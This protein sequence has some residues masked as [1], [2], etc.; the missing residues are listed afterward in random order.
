MV[1]FWQ[2]I[3][4]ESPMELRMLMAFFL[5]AL[6]WSMFKRTWALVHFD[7]GGEVEI[8]RTARLKMDLGSSAGYMWNMRNFDSDLTIGS[9]VM[10]HDNNWPG[11]GQV[12]SLEFSAT[13]SFKRSSG[14]L[15]SERQASSN[16]LREGLWNHPVSNKLDK[17]QAPG[18]NGRRKRR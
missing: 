13:P 12:H 18:Y 14:G 3:F 10:S 15:T 5:V 4:M 17:L 8:R 2:L 7:N 11:V 9:W 1:E 6:I 16:L